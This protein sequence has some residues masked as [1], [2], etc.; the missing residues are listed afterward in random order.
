M[1]QKGLRRTGRV[2]TWGTQRSSE[3][4]VRWRSRSRSMDIRG[5]REQ[6]QFRS[7]MSLSLGW[8]MRAGISA[9]NRR[10]FLQMHANLKRMASDETYR[11]ELISFRARTLAPVDAEPRQLH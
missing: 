8:S 10:G 9:E 11:R 2:D 7:P 1:Q 4:L 5:Q 3:F 6:T